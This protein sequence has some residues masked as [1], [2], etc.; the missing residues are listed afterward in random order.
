MSRWWLLLLV[1]G[2]FYGGYRLVLFYGL[3]DVVVTVVV[4]ALFIIVGMV[5]LEVRRQYG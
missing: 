2:L 3:L 4:I 1:F 5:S